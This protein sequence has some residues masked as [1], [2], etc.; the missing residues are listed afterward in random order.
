MSGGALE[1]RWRAIRPKWCAVSALLTAASASLVA[2][3]ASAQLAPAPALGLAGAANLR[4]AAEV[5]LPGTTVNTGLAWTY[6][7]AVTVGVGATDNAGGVDRG[8]QPFFVLTPSVYL[9]GDTNR[10]SV[11][12]TY[13]PSL[14]YYPSTSNQSLLTHS[15]AASATAAII[16][17]HLFFDVGAFSGISSRFGDA[18]VT[19]GTSLSRS[20][21][22]Q[23]TSV[24]LGPRYTHTF[25][26]WGTLNV[27]YRY[28]RVFQDSDNRYE[29]FYPTVNTIGAAPLGYGGTGNLETHTEYATFS[30]GEN[31][32]R[33]R[34]T[35]AIMA[36]QNGGSRLYAG[37]SAVVFD[38]VLS[39][40][41]YRW[42]TVFGSVGYQYLNYPSVGYTLSEPTWSVG[43]T[44]IPN[45]SSQ[46][47]VSYGRTAG[48]NTFQA[49]A[50]YMPTARTTLFGNYSVG[51]TSGLGYRQ[52][53]LQNTTV[54]TGGVLIDRTS[55][56]PV[57]GATFLSS[58]FTLSRVESLSAGGTLVMDRNT[59]SAGAGRQRFTQLGA[60]TSIVG[61]PT[62]AGTT[63]TSTYGFVGYQRELNPSTIFNAN[64]S[65]GVNDV[66]AYL[67][68]SGSTDYFTGIAVLTRYFTP[69]LS[70]RLAYS[71][72]EQS[73]QAIRNLPRGFGGAFSQNVI[74]ASL[75]KTF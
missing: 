17:D 18:P 8:W 28:S 39:Y 52:S 60:S 22:V 36:S 26:G 32:G 9:Y 75:T 48:E 11:R 49:Y 3:P 5:A 23:T 12:L 65:Y 30:T 27:G 72:S 73:G 6:G 44:V 47:T 21:I 54:A 37:S 20:E 58:Q 40:A 70:G 63:S 31:L 71:H 16:P 33:I 62:R 66:G 19:Q 15:L 34:N 55:G 74:L 14:I 1:P 43:A 7:G 10:L 4:S 35:A 38:D 50:F 68:S 29:Q 2:A 42:L 59:F 51:I 56:A 24:Y 57:L 67:G 61:L 53:L 46:L 69:T 64:L 13:T 41:V 25:D 45:P